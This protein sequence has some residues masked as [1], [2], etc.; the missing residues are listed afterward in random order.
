MSDL[1]HANGLGDARQTPSDSVTFWRDPGCEGLE[2]AAARFRNHSFKPH[3]HD[4]LMIG[5]ID[6]GAKSFMRERRRF[7]AEPGSIS[8][9]NAGDLHTGSRAEGEQLRY[10]ALYIPIS[11]LSDVAG[12]EGSGAAPGFRSGVLHDRRV[13]AAL[14]RMHASIVGGTSR[15]RRED[16]RFEAVRAL[17]RGHGS[18]WKPRDQSIAEASRQVRAAYA[19]IRARFTENLSVFDI[20]AAVH[21]SPYHLMRQF[22]RHV[23]IPMHT[24]QTQ[25]RVQLARTLLQQGL[26]A[27]QAALDAGFADQSH[28]SKRFKELVG[29]SPVHYQRNASASSFT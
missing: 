10:R 5:L 26:P 1:A 16:V 25:L 27:S 9:V 7:I 20:A 13:F 8:I 2:A 12:A 21:V 23:G 14:G 6:T 4:G 19:M 3:T 17:A 29:T 24:L 22:R 11:V 28:L 15:L 18:S